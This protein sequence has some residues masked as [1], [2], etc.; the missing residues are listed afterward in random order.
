MC[1]DATC[2]SLTPRDQNEQSVVHLHVLYT[3]IYE[4][5][6][7]SEIQQSYP[8]LVG[9][10]SRIQQRYVIMDPSLKLSSCRSCR[11]QLCVTSACSVTNSVQKKTSATLAVLYCFTRRKS[12]QRMTNKKA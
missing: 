4:Q 7:L 2:K 1:L 3:G 9:F 11:I 6:G 12:T 8:Y 5:S 10:H